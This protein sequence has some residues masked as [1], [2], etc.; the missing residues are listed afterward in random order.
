MNWLDGKKTY[1]VVIATLAYAAAQFYAGGIDLN[2]AVQ[3]VLAALG[4][5]GFR[6][7]MK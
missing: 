6:S 5:A 7:A 4:A 1:V 2:S 3:M